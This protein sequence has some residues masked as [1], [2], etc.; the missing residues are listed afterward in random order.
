MK[1]NLTDR[2]LKVKN[3]YYTYIRKDD[4]NILDIYFINIHL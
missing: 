2:M 3:S 4:K 1:F